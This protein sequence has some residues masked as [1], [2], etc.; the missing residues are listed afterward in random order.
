MAI[1]IIKGGSAEL[2]SQSLE[3]R[4][5]RQEE[6]V[7]PQQPASSPASSGILQDIANTTPEQIA[8]ITQAA[9]GLAPDLINP[10]QQSNDDR[11]LVPDMAT[12]AQTGN[13]RY[14]RVTPPV[15]KQE[16]SVAAQ[17]E[18]GGNIRSRA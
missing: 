1:P 10:E 11:F 9:S 15:R 7:A 8:E 3:D 17:S 18:A 4:F 2:P 5:V 12:N 6:E 13:Q 16:L 14:R